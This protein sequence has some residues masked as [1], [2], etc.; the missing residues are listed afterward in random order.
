M[1]CSW[2]CSGLFRRPPNIIRMPNPFNQRPPDQEKSPIALQYLELK[3]VVKNSLV[4]YELLQVYKNT[5]SNPIE[6]EYVFP[7]E[8]DS[9]V[10][11]MRI[12]LPDGTVLE[13]KIEEETKAQEMYA[14][15]ISEGNTA[16]MAK[17]D[18]P[19]RM[20]VNIGYVAPSAEIR[21]EFSISTPL[22][23]ELEFW[24]LY[25][26][27]CLTPKSYKTPNS[28]SFDYSTENI[29][30]PVVSAKNC[31]Y[32]IGM[33]I[34]IY[35]ETP[36]SDFSCKTYP[37]EWNLSEDA[38][39]LSG[40]F[41]PGAEYIPDI[42]IEILYKTSE[43]NTPKCIIQ[44]SKGEYAAMLSFLPVYKEPDEE[45][46]DLQG[47]TGEYF[48]VI[49]RSGSMRG[50]RIE[51]AKQAAILFI[52]S[53]PPG[54][55]FNV[56]SFGGDHSFMSVDSI[57]YDSDN[58]RN[59]ISTIERFEADMGS[60]N[61]YSPLEKIFKTEGHKD[62]PKSI[63]LL[64]DGAVSRPETVVDLVQKY[65][66][67]CTVH[68]IGIGDEVSTYLVKETARAGGGVSAF[69]SNPEELSKKVI[70]ALEKCLRPVLTDWKLQ[71]D[72]VPAPSPEKL[73][74]VFYGERFVLYANLG[75]KI[76]EHLPILQCYDSKINGSRLFDIQ[77]DMTKITPGDEIFKLWAK[78]RIEDIDITS[79]PNPQ[80]IDLSKRYGVPSRLTSYI[81][82][83]RNVNPVLGDMQF[84]K[85]PIA[86]VRDMAAPPEI[87]FVG[88]VKSAINTQPQLRMPPPIPRQPQ[89]MSVFSAM[90]PK[91]MPQRRSVEMI[92]ANSSPSL[93]EIQR[94][95]INEMKT[96]AVLS[97][98]SSN[99]FIMQSGTS[100]GDTR[101]R[102]IKI[103]DLQHIKVTNKAASP[104]K[105]PGS[106][107]MKEERKETVIARLKNT[108]TSSQI[109]A[110]KSCE[111]EQVEE[112][113]TMI[114]VKTVSGDYMSLVKLQ[115]VDGYWELNDLVPIVGVLGIPDDYNS[116]EN[117]SKIWATLLALAYLKKNFSI[118]KDEWKLVERKSIR[119]LKSQILNIEQ[120][121]EKALISI[122]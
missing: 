111:M 99:T 115:S 103:D 17:T 57:I 100:S 42:G 93:P 106:S 121:I 2:A 119:W 35:S 15:A 116:F 117:N 51:L 70:N 85:I 108:K 28:Q 67:T 76:P 112:Q 89:S 16:V 12:F 10:T 122:N 20:V 65:A 72:V 8:S 43:A 36:V 25:I 87:G 102:G 94:I 7:I 39:H 45:F 68:V 49:D 109:L 110:E 6:C 78:K 14:D 53:L 88:P 18:S 44:E 31:T 77:T 64:T 58:V 22:T 90:Q 9:V 21:V 79:L 54:S 101:E 71:W 37:F 120:A 30:F 86:K 80:I 83:Q 23:T 27:T 38:L 33:S 107:I 47:Q 84:R 95:C 96:P 46:E 62:K 74:K 69:V 4:N 98:P 11:G 91:S 66:R 52:K 59:A 29:R 104:P 92:S 73:K 32:K 75:N 114:E 118:S 61:I 63:F 41:K 19:D 97:S 56:V 40:R 34:D 24:K 50:Q 82:I 105:I 3:T 55:T 48:F 13:A 1:P 5:E 60:T 26:P 113:E 81:C